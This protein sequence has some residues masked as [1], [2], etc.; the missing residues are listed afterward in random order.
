MAGHSY[1]RFMSFSKL[2]LADALLR[3]VHLH[4]GDTH[5]AVALERHAHRVLER[6]RF[7]RRRCACARAALAAARLRAASADNTPATV[8]L[9]P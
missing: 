2:G 5:A 7:W 1:E 6:Q 4:L 3:A 9:G 8:R